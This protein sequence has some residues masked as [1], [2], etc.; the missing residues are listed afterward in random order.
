MQTISM[1][2]REKKHYKAYSWLQFIDCMSLGSSVINM[3]L[4]LT[5]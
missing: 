1:Y 2:P 3:T 4:D 5:Q